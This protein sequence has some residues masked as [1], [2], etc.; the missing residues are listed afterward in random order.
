MLLLTLSLSQIL[1]RNHV[2]LLLLWLLV[3]AALGHL[4][5]LLVLGVFVVL[6]VA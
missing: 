4:L 6:L 1:A 5:L 2:Y 3:V